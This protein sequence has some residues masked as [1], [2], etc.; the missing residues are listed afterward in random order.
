[1][2]RPRPIHLLVLTALALAGCKPG[3]VKSPIKLPFDVPGVSQPSKASGPPP[4]GFDK[5]RLEA[6][7]DRRF[8]GVGTCVI[9]AGTRNGAEAY[10]YNSNAACMNR[11]PPC[12]TFQIANALI[13]LD[14]GAITPQTVLKWNGRPQPIKAWEKDADLGA[15]FKESIAWWHQAL[16]AKVGRS[17]YQQRLKAFHYGNEAPEGPPTDF[18]QGPSAGGRLGI[19]TREQ[20]DFLHRLYD[21]E[22]PVKPEAA[23][24]VQRIMVDE[25]RDG[26]TMS[27]KTGSCASV[28]DGSRQVGWWVGRL[29]T[30]TQDYVFAA[31]MEGENGAVLPGL[32][33]QERVK[34]V[35][36][37]SGLWPAA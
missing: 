29:K 13:G 7:I 3:E 17:T 8:G 27:G 36:A 10:R 15:A 16:A 20:A 12:S 5:A 26:A 9:I 2:S 31:S 19:S 25:I 4:G 21:G 30:P 6:A 32:E 22:L 11:L 24:E 14:A 18:W 34:S 35:F 1:M 37:D 23:A 33:I 28:A